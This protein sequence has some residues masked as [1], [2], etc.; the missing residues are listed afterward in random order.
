[1]VNLV[2]PEPGEIIQDPAAG[3]GGFLIAASSSIAGKAGARDHLDEFQRHSALRGVENVIDTYRMLCMNLFLHGIDADH[4]IMGDTL[5]PLG[6]DNAF[7]DAD[8]ILSNPPFGPSGGVPTR[9]DLTVTAR[10]TNF[11][12]PFVEHCIRAFAPGG[13]A[14]VIVPDNVLFEGGRG[15]ELRRLLMRECDLHTILRLP[16]GIFYAQGIRTNV[17][18]FSRPATA[19]DED[20][21]TE[22]WIYDLRAERQNGLRGIDE[23]VSGL[24]AFVEAYG[25]DP[26][27]RSERTDLGETGRFRRFMRDEIAA[28]NDDLY[29]TWLKEEADLATGVE[30]LPPDEVAAVVER[31]LV[32]AL[33]E[34]RA[35]IDELS[36]EDLAGDVVL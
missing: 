12:F 26:Y 10:S 7:Q 27:G 19:R 2:A 30:S 18:F 32:S 31:N 23:L 29:I 28:R 16:T 22:V 36:D 3:T 17:L 15:T 24:G 25:S 9:S 21:T 14:A 20:T 34:I 33:E 5:S 8:V 4:V 11:Q 13:R 1:M 35:L 6:A